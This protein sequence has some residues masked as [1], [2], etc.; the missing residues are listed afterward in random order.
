MVGGIV[1]IGNE[2][3]DWFGAVSL[4]EIPGHAQ[5]A[6]RC[7]GSFIVLS[8]VQA[9]GRNIVMEFVARQPVHLPNL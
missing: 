6:S 2:R 1:I 7:S 5:F 3:I 4:S 9:I 8:Q